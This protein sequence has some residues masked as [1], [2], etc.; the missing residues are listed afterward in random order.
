MEM[1]FYLCRGNG[2]WEEGRD[3]PRLAAYAVPHTPPEPPR[4]VF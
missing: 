4:V 2:G 3:T 1:P